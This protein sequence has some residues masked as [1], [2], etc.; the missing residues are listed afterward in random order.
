MVFMT[1]NSQV[2]QSFMPDFGMKKCYNETASHGENEVEFHSD[3]VG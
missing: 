2:C 1:F 3:F